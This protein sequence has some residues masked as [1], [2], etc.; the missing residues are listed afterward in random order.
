MEGACGRNVLVTFK[1]R[2][3]N[4]FRFGIVE[5]SMHVILANPGIKSV[6][7]HALKTAIFSQL[8]CFR[9]NLI[10]LFR[11]G[12]GAGGHYRIQSPELLFKFH[13]PS[14]SGPSNFASIRLDFYLSFCYF[15]HVCQAANII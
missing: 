4:L 11:D 1:P 10:M 12:E 15:G 14:D 2:C 9:K 5:S 13:A 8:Y 6:L 7:Q 3:Q